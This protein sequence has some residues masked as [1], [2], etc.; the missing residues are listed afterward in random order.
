VENPVDNAPIEEHAR[1]AR[2]TD[3]SV[4]ATRA[5]TEG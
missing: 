3:V 2:W 4:Y 1:V 5:D